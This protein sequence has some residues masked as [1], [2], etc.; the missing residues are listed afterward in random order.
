[1][2]PMIREMA[3]DFIDQFI[4]RGTADVTQELFTPLPAQFNSCVSRA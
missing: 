2:Q 3:N 4:E 1:M